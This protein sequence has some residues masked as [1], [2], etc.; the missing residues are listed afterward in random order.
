MGDRCRQGGAFPKV[1]ELSWP[2]IGWEKSP[3]GV[4]LPAVPARQPW[5]HPTPSQTL[6]SAAERPHLEQASCQGFLGV[7]ENGGV[8]RSTWLPPLPILCWGPLSRSP[9]PFTLLCPAPHQTSSPRDRCGPLL[10]DPQPRRATGL[11]RA[12][13]LVR[14]PGVTSPS[15]WQQQ[16]GNEACP[17]SEAGQTRALRGPPPVRPQGGRPAT[18]ASPEG[19]P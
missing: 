14:A 12:Q 5:G 4:W 11:G 10:E 3:L 2:T 7:V 8:A 6:L 1:L 13:R 16:R 17:T 19:H 18:V 15:P 9:T